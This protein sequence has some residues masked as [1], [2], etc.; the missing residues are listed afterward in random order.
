MS[1]IKILIFIFLLLLLLLVYFLVNLLHHPEFMVTYE[2]LQRS[3]HQ[4]QQSGYHYETVLAQYQYLLD[5]KAYFDTQKSL[6]Q[7][8]YAEVK[9]NIFSFIRFFESGFGWFDS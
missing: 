5:K 6:L 1:E 7:A 2:T 9:Y 8:H 3:R 4:Y